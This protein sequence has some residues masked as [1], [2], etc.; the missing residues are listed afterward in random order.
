M[1]RRAPAQ[2]FCKFSE[3]LEVVL[4]QSFNLQRAGQHATFERALPA[5]GGVT[6]VRAATRPLARGIDSNAA[7]NSPHDP[8]EATLVADLS[9]GDTS[10]LGDMPWAAA[11]RRGR[12][13]GYSF[14]APTGWL[15][16]AGA[17]GCCCCSAAAAAATSLLMS[18]RQPVN[19]AASRAF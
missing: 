16:S 1:G 6:E 13:Q 12:H 4:G 3:V 15:C 2:P 17:A 19:L 10:P 5:L 18:M 11:P 14:V 7:I 8:H 9:A